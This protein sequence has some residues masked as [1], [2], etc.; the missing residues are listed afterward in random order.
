MSLLLTGATGFLGR[1]ILLRALGEEREIFAP[2]RSPGKLI[3]QLQFEKR[4]LRG[5]HILSAVPERWPKISPGYAILGGGVLFERS[6]SDY[7]CTNV[8][9]TLATLRALPEECRTVVISS[10]SAGGPTPSGKPSRSE[11]DSDAPIT[12]YGESKL[13]M[14]EAIRREF[15]NRPITILRPPMILGPR[16]AATLPL[17]RMARGRIRIKPGLRAKSYSFIAVE[18]LVAAIFLALANEPLAQSF[19]VASMRPMT[20]WQLIASAATA[21]NARG[22]TVPVPHFFVRILSRVVDAIPAL[23]PQAPSLTRDRAR[24]IWADRWVVDG[25]MFERLTGWRA[26]T[27]LG[28]AVQAAHNYYVREGKL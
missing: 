6:R 14:E 22:L 8:D 15:P 2:V 5:V 7:F 23:R 18:D 10:Q 1:N 20:D 12:W 17:F 21:C 24:E 13:A 9:W 19:Y 28:D 16:D 3:Q 27:G 26:T 11:A 4:D 25:S